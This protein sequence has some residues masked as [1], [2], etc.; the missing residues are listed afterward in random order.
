[1]CFRLIFFLNFFIQTLFAAQ[2]VKSPS[3]EGGAGRGLRVFLAGSSFYDWREDL[4]QAFSEKELTFFDPLYRVSM[5]RELGVAWEQKHI[6]EADVIV[7]WIPKGDLDNLRSLSITTI[8]ELGRFVEMKDKPLIVGVHEDHPYK[9][10]LTLQLKGIKEDLEVF[11]HLED[12]KGPI[13]HFQ[14]SYSL[15]N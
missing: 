12:L 9:R 5:K 1:M 7:V 10:E 11:H 3:F 6:A 15:I 8:F 14:R 13:E 2:V 4:I